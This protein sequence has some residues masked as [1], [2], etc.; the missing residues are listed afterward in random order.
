MR[1]AR[2]IKRDAKQLWRLSLVNGSLDENRARLVVERVIE[3]RHTGKS[4]IL[5]Q[6]LRL[7]RLD[8]ARHA[9]QVASAAPLDADT[10]AAVEEGLARRYGRTIATTFVVDPTLLAGMRLKVGSDVY[11][12]SVKGGLAALEARF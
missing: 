11:D 2:Q 1:R 3:S 9:A 4:A 10:R 7:V 6:F 12:G 8:R 5:S